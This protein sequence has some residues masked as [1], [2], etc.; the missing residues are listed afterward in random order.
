MV[1]SRI[2]LLKDEL[3]SL[4]WKEST[5]CDTD[6]VCRNV[7]EA[8]SKVNNLINELRQTTFDLYGSIRHNF[9]QT[10]LAVGSPLRDLVREA[11][12][13]QQ[14]VHAALRDAARGVQ[15]SFVDFLKLWAEA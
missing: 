6:I 15:E 10:L 9:D 11:Q 14:S 7:V 2:N 13:L 3:N 5:G 1:E 4:K 12:E 8:K